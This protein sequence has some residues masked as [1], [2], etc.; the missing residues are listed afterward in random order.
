MPYTVSQLRTIANFTYKYARRTKRKEEKKRK[1]I[2]E[3]FLACLT[4]MGEGGEKNRGK[5]GKK[6]IH[7]GARCPRQSASSW[8]TGGEGEKKKKFKKKK[9]KRI[10]DVVSP[11]FA[12]PVLSS[13]VCFSPAKRAVAGEGEK[14]RGRKKKEKRRKRSCGKFSRDSEHLRE[15]R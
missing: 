8:E 13:E 12:V 14:R 6:E 11:P 3:L 9:G 1:R 4:T 2:E 7:L 15:N 10:N 5:E